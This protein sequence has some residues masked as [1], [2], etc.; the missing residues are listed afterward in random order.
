MNELFLDYIPFL[1]LFYII[2]YFN[3]TAEL[4]GCSLQKILSNNYLLKHLIGIMGMYLFI[5]ITK[6]D[7][8]PIKSLI[9]TLPMYL[10][11]IINSR[12]NYISIIIN[13]ILLFILYFIDTHRIYQ[14]NNK[15][16]SEEKN[17]NY[18]IIEFIIFCIILCISIIGFIDHIYN[19]NSN[20][21]IKWSWKKFILNKN[22]KC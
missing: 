2:V 5:N 17:N 12:G 8:T 16:L 13:F 22:I 6:E 9:M 19:I 20:N 21:N 7:Q 4:L 18:I 1:V 3:F 14:L 11:F 15:H 10:L